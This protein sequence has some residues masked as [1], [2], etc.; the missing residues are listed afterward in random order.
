MADEQVTIDVGGR[1]ASG[2]G[3]QMLAGEYARYTAELRSRWGERSPLP[4]EEIAT[5]YLELRNEL[6]AEC[7]Q[8]GG[9]LTHIGDGQVVM[10][11]RNTAA[12]YANMTNA[13]RLDQDRS[14]A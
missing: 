5:P 1:H 3:F 12:E 9:D 13:L 14:Q 10:A 4:Y 8:L 2:H 11:A 7:E 6:L